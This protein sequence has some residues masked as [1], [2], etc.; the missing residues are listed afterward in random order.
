R[1]GDMAQ[2]EQFNALG[3]DDA[4]SIESIL[5]DDAIDFGALAH[6][7][8]VGADAIFTWDYERS[9]AGLS[10]IYERAKS[11]HGNGTDDL[12]WPTEVDVEAVGR[13]MQAAIAH[14]R[15]RLVDRPGSPLRSGT[16]ADWTKLAVEAFNWRMSQFLHGE[17]GALICTAKIV[18]TVPW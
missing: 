6:S 7:T 8:A 4:N 3:S 13:E 15:Q 10:N 5:A 17:Q 9:R 1:G 14:V 11:A 18:E 12:D 2:A 16:D